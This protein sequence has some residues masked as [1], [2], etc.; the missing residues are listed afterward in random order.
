MRDV[1]SKLQDLR[2]LTWTERSSSSGTAGCFLK[3]REET[4]GGTWFYKLSCY[5]SYRGIYGHECVNEVIASRLMELLSIPHLECRLV[6][7]LVEID[8]ASGASLLQSS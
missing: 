1:I 8:G 5:D 2:R 4:G 6:H 3:A 7:T